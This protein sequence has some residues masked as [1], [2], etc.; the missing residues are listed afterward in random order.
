MKIVLFHPSLTSLGGA[1]MQVLEH[2]HLLRDQ[3]HRVEVLTFEYD[4]GRWRDRLMDIPVRVTTRRHWT[5]PL[6]LSAVSKLERRARRVC[7]DLGDCD[8]VIAHNH[9]CHSMLGAGSPVPRKVWY[10]HEPPRALYFREAGPYMAGIT[11]DQ[12]RRSSVA[13]AVR[14]L[15]HRHDVRLGS[16]RST[17]RAKREVDHRGVQGLSFTLANSQFTADNFQ[18]IY[19]VQPAGVVYPMVRLGG[20]GISRRGLDRSGLQVLV[21]SRMELL[22]NQEGVLRGFAEFHRRNPT[23]HLHLV[24]AGEQRRPL[25]ALAETLLP[26]DA[27]TFHGFLSSEALSALYQRCDVFALLPLDEPF[28]MVFP[29]AASRGLLLVGPD[30]GGPQ[31]IMEGGRYGWGVDPFDPEAFADALARIWALSDA[32]VQRRREEADAACRARYAPEVVG[33]QLLRVLD[34]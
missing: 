27:A 24:G 10:C 21:Q 13:L 17:L 33:P 26:P 32:E 30:H 23:A 18:R 11:E 25:Q 29:E 8:M 9:P 34:L 20:S 31:E 2:G 4:E 12:A 1:E 6:S 28:G 15:L 16:M 5:D 14:A 7:Q 3:G 22:K 19:G